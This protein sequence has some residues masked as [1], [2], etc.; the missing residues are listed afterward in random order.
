ML[1]SNL[2]DC[3]EVD[4]PVGKLALKPEAAGKVRV[5]AMVDIWTQSALYPLHLWLFDLLSRIPNDGTFDQTASVKRGWEKA[6]VSG[7]SFGYDLSAA[8]DR[9]PMSLQI[10]VLSQFF[11]ADL[12]NS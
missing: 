12:A 4:L 8:T 1:S 2:E 5:F 10:E 11:G 9:L 6:R 3:A 7:C